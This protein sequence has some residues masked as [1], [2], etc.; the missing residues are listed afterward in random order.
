[1]PAT[2]SLTRRWS[3]GA[4][5]FGVWCSL[6]SPATAELFSLSGFD[7]VCID[8]QHGLVGPD[9]LWPMLQAAARTDATLLVRV[10]A[11]DPAAI[12]RALDAG[13][14][15][16]IVPLVESS[17]EAASAAAACRF[18]PTGRRSFGTVRANAFQ[19]IDPAVANDTVVCIV[20]IE[21]V[22]GVEHADEICA[23]GGVDAVYIG[24]SDLA[25]SMGES[26]TS[27]SANHA[28][29]LAAVLRAGERHGTPVGIHASAGEAARRYSAQ[30]FR[31][32]T[33]TSDV[34][35]LKRGAVAELTA[36]RAT[37]AAP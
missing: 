34:A 32:C 7:Y 8:T 31:M 28:A 30:G 9:A 25:I 12:G 13:A 37:G 3:E 11:N 27:T 22:A 20:M 29:A 10:S 21:T 6:P 19:P 18:P 36:A 1:M 17:A 2:S 24:P 33:V 5:A 4:T 26:P 35:L 23:T 16:V 14:G 15:G